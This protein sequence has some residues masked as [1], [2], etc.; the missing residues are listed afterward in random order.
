MAPITWSRT[1]DLCNCY[2][3]TPSSSKSLY[4]SLSHSLFQYPLHWSRSQKCLLCYPLHPDS[5]DLFAFTWTDPDN[6]CSQQLTWKVLPQGFCDSPHFFGQALASDLTS[7][8]LTLSTVL[9]YVDDLLCSPLLTYSQQHTIQLLNFLVYQ[10][11]R[12]PPTKIQ[13]S[14]PRV[15]HLRVLLT[16]TKRCTTTDRKSLISTLP[17]PTSKRDLVFLGVS[18][19][20][21]PLDSNFTP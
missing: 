11:Y 13:L 3:H 2:P 20:S 12:V 7:L 16:Q 14:I 9:Q 1:W 17:L 19:I 8:D 18:W 10:G 6:H 4:S 5:Q 21:T 15:T